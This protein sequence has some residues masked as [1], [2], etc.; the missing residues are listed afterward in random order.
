MSKVQEIIHQVAELFRDFGIKS[1]TMDDISSSLGISKKTLY[2]YVSDKNDLVNKVIKASIEQKESYLLQLIKENNHPIDELVSIAKF[3]IIEISSLHPSVQF[4][5]K[6]YH[7]KAWMLFEQHKQSFVYNCVVNNLKEG[8][9]INVY[10]NN[11]DPDI[12]ARL[13]TGAIPLVFD[14]SVF[15]PSN[16]SFKN[17]FSEFM[18]HHIRGIATQKGIEYLKELIKNDTNNP[19]I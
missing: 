15:P 13:H 18:R 19:F 16:Y 5:L 6:K 3:S 17:V 8:I 7:P 1:L 12:V 11:I 10:R 4:D 9:K 2:K 14:S